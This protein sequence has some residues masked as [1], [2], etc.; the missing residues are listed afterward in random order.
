MLKMMTEDAE[1]TYEPPEMIYDKST[2]DVQILP[3][4]IKKRG[5][6]IQS[7]DDLNREKAALLKEMGVPDGDLNN[8]DAAGDIEGASEKIYE[9]EKMME[10]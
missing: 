4:K 5:T 8:L 7:Y 2:G 9:V 1:F 6:M 10:D 3:K